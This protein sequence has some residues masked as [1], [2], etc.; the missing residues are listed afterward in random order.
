MTGTSIPR[1]LLPRGGSLLSP[2]LS[3]LRAPATL[4]PVSPFSLRHA[5]SSS[6]SKPI[7]LE[8]PSKFNP[9]SHPARLN[10]RMPKSY[11]PALSAKELEKQKVK[12]YPHMMPP[13]G[14]FMFWFLTNRM[15]HV[16]ITLSVLFSLA[17]FTFV[18][19]FKHTSPFADL[20]PE[21]SLFTSHPLEFLGRWFDVYKMHVAHVSAETSERRKRRV[22]DV[23]KRSAYRKAHGMEEND[24]GM[25]GGWT[26]KTDA[27]AL[28]PALEGDEGS[29]VAKQRAEEN[30][31]SDVQEA[32]ADGKKSYTDFEG[33]RRPIKKWFGIW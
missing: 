21:N 19:N 17:T 14:T 24:G 7:V 16:Y 33:R 10:R 27:E 22:D 2:P 32:E 13:E 20:L 26:A 23:E 9:P 11:G 25:F 15:I 18:Q 5:S 28:G 8:K 1:F 12:Q 31:A 30:T 4:R 29:P 3:I 6:H